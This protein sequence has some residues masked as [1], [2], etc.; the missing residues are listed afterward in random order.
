MH[1]LTTALSICSKNTCPSKTKP[2][3]TVRRLPVYLVLDTSGSMRG[4]PISAV[5]DGIVAL[6]RQLRTDP[7]ALETVW[8]SVIT[9]DDTARQVVPLTELLQFQSPVLTVD[10]GLTALGAGLSLAASCINVEVA[11]SSRDRKGDW[12]PL[13]FVMTDGQPTDD[14]RGGINAFRQVQTGTIIACA[15]GPN[16]DTTALK[17]LTE[18]VVEIEKLDEQSFA[19]FFRW[20]SASVSTAS[21]KIDLT[22]TDPGI[23][24]MPALPPEVKLADKLRKGAPDGEAKGPFNAERARRAANLDKYGN[25]DG[26]EFDLA[27]DGAFKGLQVAVLHLYTGEGF[28][29]KLPE[30]AL[31]DK[32][33]AVHRWRNKPPNARELASVLKQSCQLW[34][35]SD[36]VVKLNESHLSV[37]ANFFASGHGVYIWGDNEPYFA[38]ANAVARR[39]LNSGMSGNSPGT[40]VLGRQPGNGNPG[41][42]AD[43]PVL[44]GLERL[45]EGVT[46]ASI[47]SNERLKPLLVASHGVP[48]TATYEYDGRRAILDG[49]FTRLYVNWDSAGTARYVKNAAAWLVNYERFGLPCHQ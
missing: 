45:F 42:I 34:I 25:P 30:A 5:T 48:V 10:K 44:F 41:M 38:D 39:L 31:K 6:M 28:D 3:Q 22:K 32:G 23:E 24:D 1:I 16:A 19:S 20:V 27:K 33:F 40:Q 13:V 18:D 37:I 17:E 43:H 7:V 14:Y 2:I 8:L 29:F 15:A 36:Q 11:R 9:F 49:G 4:G 12:R 21:V 46:I 47:T 26:P 35:V